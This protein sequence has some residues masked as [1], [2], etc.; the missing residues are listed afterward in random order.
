MEEESTDYRSDT[1]L[2][3]DIR[4]YIEKRIQLFVI[5]I[6]EQ[7]SLYI[8]NS[9]QK[10]L[11]MFLLGGAL[12][13]VLFALAFYL[14]ELIGNFSAGFALVSLPLIFSGYFFMKKKSK[15]VTENIQS[16]VIGK[17]LENFES[18]KEKK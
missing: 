17:I 6:A 14:G 1:N 7:L 8:A 9:F 13:F 15:M 2:K 3:T 5:E 18:D 16:E 10:I 4:E 11:G 12:F